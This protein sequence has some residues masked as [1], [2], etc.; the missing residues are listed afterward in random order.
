[1]LTNRRTLPWI[2]GVARGHRCRVAL[3]LCQEDQGALRLQFLQRGGQFLL[4]L[5]LREPADHGARSAEGCRSRRVCGLRLP[6]FLKR[7][8]CCTFGGNSGCLADLLFLRMLVYGRM[9]TY[10]RHPIVLSRE[11]IRW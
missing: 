8:H 9:S 6:D 5:G 7:Q 4:R 11:W 2:D 1:P 10:S 3:A